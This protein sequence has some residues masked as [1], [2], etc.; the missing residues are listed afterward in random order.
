[1]TSTPTQ[2]A[3]RSEVQASTARTPNRP[4]SQTPGV[5]SEVPSTTA[6]TSAASAMARPIVAI[7]WRTPTTART[8]TGWR[9]AGA[10]LSSRGSKGLIGG[11]AAGSR[12]A[13]GTAAGMFCV[14]SRLRKTQ[15]V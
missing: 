5:R 9:A 1:M 11:C 3:T 4:A 8:A 14:L 6:T 2:A 15:Y 12:H 10:V 13:T 7:P